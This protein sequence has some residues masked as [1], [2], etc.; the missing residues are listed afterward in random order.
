MNEKIIKKKV[1]QYF[2][3][4]I[5][6][7]FFGVYLYISIKFGKTAQKHL[8]YFI[9]GL[10]MFL[11]G[12]SF[13][14]TAMEKIAG[15]QLKS[16]IA[17]LTSTPFRGLLTG[18]LVTS[19]I[20][21]SSA[22]TV[23]VV[24]FTNTGLMNLR[25]AIGVIL[26]A[27]IGTTITAQLIAFKLEDW[28]W[29]IM[30]LGTLFNLMGKTKSKR[31]WGEFLIGFALLF[32]GMSLMGD[33]LKNYKEHELFKQVFTQFSTN[34][35]LGV[36]AGLFVTLIIQSSS[37]TVGLTMSLASAGAFGTGRE[38]LYAAVPIIFGDN[39]GT[40]ITAILASIGTSVNAK[41]AALA[42]TIFNVWGTILFLPLLDLYIPFLELTSDNLVRQIANSHTLFN[43]INAFLVLPF[44]EWLKKIVQVIIPDKDDQRKLEINITLDKRLLATPFIALEHVT[45]L[46]ENLFKNCYDNIAKIISF[47][48]KKDLEFDEAFSIYSNLKSEVSQSKHAANEL[49]SFLI[50]LSSTTDI[51][52]R[53]LRHATY[54]IN[55]IRDMDI[56]N[57]QLLNFMETILEFLETGNSIPLDQL[58]EILIGLE[59]VQEIIQKF[60]NSLNL[61]KNMSDEI[62][63]R[64]KDY[65]MLEREILRQHF[66]RINQEH[67][68]NLAQILHL[69]L[70]NA[71]KSM[72]RNLEYL[73]LHS[74][75]P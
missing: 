27:N 65:V 75:K 59:H 63:I 19:I 25:Q 51:T 34:R 3:F 68:A 46:A 8:G 33:T 15:D 7:T 29:T 24:G 40:T 20:Q 35:L 4:L 6:F 37:A 42:H 41:R 52:E 71:I 48:S 69:N 60:N 53:P 17:S 44:V 5:T 26:G 23:M 64:I 11:F 31:S 32:I 18:V 57:G 39:I 72:L 30:F 47:I 13:M 49:Q 28:A 36:L 2:K 56:L 74:V 73:A 61:D 38:A 9:G 67:V 43:V 22:T 66:A 14:S 55:Q 12:M 45:K 58:N 10:G 70:L 16:L 54:L 50:R 21:S 1:K 62:I